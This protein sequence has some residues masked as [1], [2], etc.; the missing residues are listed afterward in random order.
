MKYKKMMKDTL[1]TFRP[2]G[3]NDMLNYMDDKS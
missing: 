2:G 3:S 1:G